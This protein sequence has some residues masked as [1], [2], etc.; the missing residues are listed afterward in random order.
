MN[1]VSLATNEVCF[2]TLSKYLQLQE[3]SY[4]AKTS[5]DLRH[6]VVLLFNNFM[7]WKTMYEL[8]AFISS[9]EEFV[10]KTN[11]KLPIFNTQ[12]E[13]LKYWKRLYKLR[14]IYPGSYFESN[15]QFEILIGLCRNDRGGCCCY[16]IDPNIWERIN[17]NMFSGILKYVI[18]PVVHGESTAYS[19]I[20]KA[21]RQNNVKLLCEIES[22]IDGFDNINMTDYFN[23]NNDISIPVFKILLKYGPFNNVKP[24][25]N[26]IKLCTIENDIETLNLYIN[27][28]KFKEKINKF[29]NPFARSAI[30]EKVNLTTVKYLLDSGIINHNILLSS[31]LF[32]SEDIEFVRGIV[33]LHNRHR[34]SYPAKQ[35]TKALTV[36]RIADIANYLISL[37]AVKSTENFRKYIISASKGSKNYYLAELIEEYS[38]YINLE[39]LI[40]LIDEISE[41]RIGSECI[42]YLF[43]LP[44]PLTITQIKFDIIFKFYYHDIDE[45]MGGLIKKFLKDKRMQKTIPTAIINYP[46][47]LKLISNIGTHDLSIGNNFL[48]STSIIK[49]ICH[50]STDILLKDPRVI[51]KLC[52]GSSI[53]PNGHPVLPITND[54]MDNILLD[55]EQ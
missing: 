3:L 31:Y 11:V 2:L 30:I 23:G 5:K 18:K 17:I 27:K 24:N 39:F 54:I 6:C 13:A 12:Y 34:H 42:E 49:G 32:E 44:A 52:Q 48:L 20:K 22:F 36:C 43:N 21:I 19:F 7:Y 9:V 46:T 38:Q 16:N 4:L 26:L 40:E 53:L 28:C 14:R 41:Y 37:G 29:Y 10:E 25:Y 45:N 50:E 47:L 8:N 35:L 51:N 15:D 55:L 33:E 1:F